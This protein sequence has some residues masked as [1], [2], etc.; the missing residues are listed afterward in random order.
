MQDHIDIARKQ[1]QVGAHRGTH[2]PL[3]AITLNRFAEHAASSKPNA[4]AD[5]G[6][7]SSLGEEVCH[8]R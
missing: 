7:R 4:W 1:W 5:R 6:T 2:T 8:R 3:D